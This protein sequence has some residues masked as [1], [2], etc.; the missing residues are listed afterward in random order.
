M[1]RRGTCLLAVVLLVSCVP[2][3]KAVQSTSEVQGVVRVDVTNV[4]EDIITV[5]VKNQSS[6][7]P[8]L[9]DRDAIKL[10]TSR[11]TLDR[12]PG[13]ASN[14]YTVAPGSH[15]EVNVRFAVDG[16]PTGETVELLLDRAIFPAAGGER[17]AA[18]PVTLVRP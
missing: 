2:W 13:G 3:L 7:M 8:L 17:I 6:N 4:M 1:L 10:K 5:D 16:L 11:G 9:V 18:P 15:R 14:T 12:K